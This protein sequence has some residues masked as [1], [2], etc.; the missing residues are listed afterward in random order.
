MQ[1]GYNTDIEH[2]GVTVHIQTEDHGL[3]DNKITTQVFFSGRILDSRTIS[4]AEAISTLVE[5]EPRDTEITKRMRAIH[6]HFLNRIREGAYDAKLPIDGG[7]A[8]A[9]AAGAP[10]PSKVTL[11]NI[12]AE[13]IESGLDADVAVDE[14]V[15]ESLISSEDDGSDEFDFEQLMNQEERTWRGLENDFNSDLGQALRDALA[16]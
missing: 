2:H 1:M 4:Y 14:I 12:P 9:P 13:A 7:V 6:R 10:A 15:I 3:G 11:T 5:E 16:V 8:A